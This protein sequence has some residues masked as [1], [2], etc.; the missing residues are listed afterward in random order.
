MQS[1]THGSVTDAGVEKHGYQ[2]YRRIFERILSPL[3]AGKLR[4]VYPTGEEVSYGLKAPGPEAE[5]TILNPVFFKRCILYGEVGL[6]ESY[7]DG[8]WESDDIVGL[9]SWFLINLE[10][11]QTSSS[12]KY[13]LTNLLQVFHRVRH[14]VR[15]NDIRGARRNI[16]EHYDLGNEFFKV[17][18]DRNM[19]YSCA[20]FSSPDQS[21][22]SAQAEK[23]DRLCRK[24]K[25]VPTDHVL[26][27][28]GGWGGFAIHAARNSG[29]QVT[30]I[31][32]SKEQL[33]YARERAE[34]EG[35]SS[36]IEF[37]LTDYRN[38]TG[39]FDKIVS[40][41][42]IEAVG[43][44]YFKSYF[45]KCHELLKRHGL[46]AIQA[47]ICPDSRYASHRNS[48]DW[49]QKHIFPGGL[50]PSIA[51]M[52]KAINETGNLQLYN[53]EEMGLHY[54]RTLATW[55]DNFNQRLGSVLAEGF[56][57]RF[58]RKWNYYLTSSEA[59]MRTRNLTVV[60][61]LY[62]RPNNLT[63]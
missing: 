35:L 21:L 27:I 53:L 10:N 3:P 49:M 52:N 51:I 5:L 61:A 47:I 32:I 26:E 34:A 50:L 4:V 17:F 28:G 57:E 58:I 48:V 40:I 36:Q 23:Y 11:A 45:S 38:M 8:D 29:C 1:R 14:F 46:L 54:A 12:R 25:L 7:V 59:A 37:Q 63:L 9:L 55:R 56:T 2:T 41:E 43:H 31:T 30:S 33:K 24:L 39:K 60:Q 22:E 19:T 13:P 44:E 42:M 15:R 18:L 62:S 16:S 6:G 20:H